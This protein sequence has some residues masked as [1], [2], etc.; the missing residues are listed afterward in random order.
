MMKESHKRLHNL[1]YFWYIKFFLMNFLKLLASVK[2]CLKPYVEISLHSILISFFN[3]SI[4][5]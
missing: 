2:N 1:D 4:A 3:C 5:L